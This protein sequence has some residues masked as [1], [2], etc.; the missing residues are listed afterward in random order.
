MNLTIGKHRIALFLA[1][2]LISLPTGKITFGQE[3]FRIQKAS[4]EYDLTV[5]IAKCD[6][7]S[8]KTTGLCSGPARISLSRKGARAPFQVLSLR[9]VEVNEAQLAYNPRINKKRRVIY[10][11]EYSFIFGDFNFDGKED[12]AICNGRNGG[13]GAP[14]YDVYLYNATSNRFVE[15]KW[16]SRLTQGYLG[17]FFI[18]QKRR[19]LVALSKSGCC[20]HETEKYKIANNKPVLV[21]RIIEDATGDAGEGFVVV[22]TKKLVNGKWIKRV[23][24]ER[25]EPR[26]RDERST[27]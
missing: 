15:N 3:T 13:Y 26:D 25:L 16:L 17:L 6:A 22:T 4:I 10:D 8:R 1:G 11:D 19:Q 18:D 24:R 12:L 27:S 7:E 5:Q 23:K 14:S 2:L 21:E 20:Y 9:N